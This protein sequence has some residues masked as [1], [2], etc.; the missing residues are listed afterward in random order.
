[1]TAAPLRQHGETM[2]KQYISMA[3]VLVL[4]V[5]CMTA[6]AGARPSP[7]Q[8]PATQ[9]GIDAG[10]CYVSFSQELAAFLSAAEAAD[11]EGTP[12]E[13][14][15]ALEGALMKGARTQREGRELLAL[16]Q[17]PRARGDLERHVATAMGM[18]AQAL[19]MQNMQGIP[20]SGE[21]I[22]AGVAL[23][24]AEV[25][26]RCDALL[27]EMEVRYAQAALQGADGVNPDAKTCATILRGAYLRIRGA[28]PSTVTWGS[29]PL[30]LPTSG[31]N[32]LFA[33]PPS[34]GVPDSDRDG[35]DDLEERAYGTD[36]GLADTDGDGIPDGTEAAGGTDPLCADTD[37]DGRH[38]GI[39]PD[40]T[41]PFSDN[42]FYDP[43]NDSDGDGLSDERERAL[44]TNPFLQ[45]SDNDGLSDYH[46]VLLGTNP[47]DRDT[48]GDGVPD[49]PDH[50]PLD[51]TVGQSGIDKDDDEEVYMAIYAMVFVGAAI[52]SLFGC[53]SCPGIAAK[54]AY[55]L[56]AMY[57]QEQE[58]IRT[59]TDE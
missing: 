2:T 40:P 8:P 45:D 46:E 49:L 18:L 31:I 37:G 57:Y 15:D 17:S 53:A 5:A 55:D 59:G 19:G 23:A 9:G 42:P 48:D 26:S 34:G 24:V 54:A 43:R 10:K 35:L 38:D 12:Q 29:I 20:C 44:G 56:L 14:L 27:D 47:L 11:A 1:M 32:A 28:G 41:T 13:R 4:L 36:P 30:A 50:D 6:P 51:P 7:C 22:R 3:L 58:E 39:D 33:T 21:E 16:L 52:G 25:Q